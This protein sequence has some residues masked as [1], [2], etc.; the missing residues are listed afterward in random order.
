MWLENGITKLRVAQS[1]LS[2]PYQLFFPLLRGMGRL[3]VW[4]LSLEKVKPKCPFKHVSQCPDSGEAFCYF[5]VGPSSLD[6]CS[7]PP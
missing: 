6:K 5:C 3:I 7:K 2:G 4:P 1:I